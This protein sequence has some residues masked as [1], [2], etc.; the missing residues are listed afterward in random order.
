MKSFDSESGSESEPIIVTSIDDSDS[1]TSNGAKLPA[2]A[3]EASSKPLEQDKKKL[4]W[5][6]LL[7]EKKLLEIK[8]KP[9]VL[10]V[11]Y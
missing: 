11:S 10:P 9:P 7:E 8:K 6:L 5:S 2:P 3:T 4:L 1:E